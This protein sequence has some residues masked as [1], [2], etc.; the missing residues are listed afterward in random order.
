MARRKWIP[1][2]IG[3][4]ILV[5]V[6]GIG[7]IGGLVWMVTRQVSVQ[8]V[9]AQTGEQEFEKLRA[10]FAGQKPFIELPADGDE[11]GAVVHRE[12]AK[13]AP[14]TV[15]TIHLRVLVPSDGKLVKLDLPF[16][17]LRLMGSKPVQFR[18][19]E[20]SGF[21][22]ITLKVT[23]EEVER[24]GPG[25]IIDHGMKDGERLLIWTE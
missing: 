25:L 20:H 24:R 22:G 11:A 17:M 8:E 15:S 16:W 23:A 5:V 3:I 18:S 21:R 14:G 12:L 10:P 7:L 6:V 9:S 2:V 13:H 4:V 1:I 19:S